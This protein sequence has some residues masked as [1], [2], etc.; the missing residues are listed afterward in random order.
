[1][2]HRL[3]QTILEYAALAV[4]LPIALVTT[5]RHVVRGDFQ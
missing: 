2:S 4:V 5:W 3:V 1:M